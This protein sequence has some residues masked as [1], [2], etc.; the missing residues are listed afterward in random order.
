MTDAVKERPILFSGEMVR[1]ILDGTKTATRR[2]V[3]GPNADIVNSYELRGM[4]DFPDGTRRAVF[5]HH[6]EEPFSVRCPYG[7]PGDRVWIRETWRVVSAAEGDI[8]YRATESYQRFLSEGD[9]E[10]WKRWEAKSWG[11]AGAVWCPAIYMP[12]WASRLSREIVST[13]VE[14]LHSITEA[15][16]KAEGVEAVNGHEERGA[17]YGRGPSHREGFAQ[18]WWDIN[19][20]ESLAANPYVWVITFRRVP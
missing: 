5:D 13:R 12:R 20:R 19:G 9:R 18:V 14:R 6:T 4:Q 11:K 8:G 3:K 16:A 2:V 17:W 7:N 15:D 1:A 10:W